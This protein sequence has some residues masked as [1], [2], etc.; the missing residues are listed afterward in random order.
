MTDSSVSSSTKLDNGAEIYIKQA[1]D[2]ID[3]SAP[4]ALKQKSAQ[5][6]DIRPGPP[7]VALDTKVGRDTRGTLW[8]NGRS[9]IWVRDFL[10][11]APA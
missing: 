11:N 6:Y 4:Y 8:I 1:H 7:R 2:S 9:I 5:I 10:S 3:N